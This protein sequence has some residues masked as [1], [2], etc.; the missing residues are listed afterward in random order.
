MP[1]SVRTHHLASLLPGEKNFRLSKSDRAF[2]RDVAR[3]S[4]VNKK[5]ASNHFYSH[6]KTGGAR[7][8]DRLQKV[9]LIQ[10]IVI[11][12][13]GKQPVVAYQFASKKI[14]AAF[15]G[16][17]PK[18]GASRSDHHELITSE[19]FYHL[20]R[21]DSFRLPAHFSSNEKEFF[22][23]IV[24]GVKKTYGVPDA[25]Y[26]D[27]STGELV[28]VEADAGNYNQSQIRNKMVFWKEKG[29]KQL[30]GQPDRVNSRVN[31]VGDS[32]QVVRL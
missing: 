19:M 1:K 12:V 20:D 23:Q 18:T 24:D 4:L 22:T 15:G 25:V 13:S 28:A 27:R 17:L 30:W 14:A 6:L 31:S 16:H 32:I 26:A 2:L 11:R 5:H 29:I 9:G 3:L 10:K 7:S 8:L 21:P